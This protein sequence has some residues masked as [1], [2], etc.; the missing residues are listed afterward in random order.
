VVSGNNNIM[1]TD[2]QKI[3]D[4]MTNYLQSWKRSL[5]IIAQLR[6]EI[7]NNPNLKDEILAN[8]QGKLVEKGIPLPIAIEMAAEMSTGEA[9]IAACAATC[10][11]TGCCVT[12]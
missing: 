9:N 4:G 6:E 7:T 10:A 12:D 1:K 5:E 2:C 3:I 11:C 8:P